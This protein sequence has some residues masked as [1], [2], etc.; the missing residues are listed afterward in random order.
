VHIVQKHLNNHGKHVFEAFE[1]LRQFFKTAQ[2]SRKNP[3]FDPK[4]EGLGGHL[5]R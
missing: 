3:V 1:P 4:K 5:S 2:F